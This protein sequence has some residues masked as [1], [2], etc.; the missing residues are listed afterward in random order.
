MANNA[1]AYGFGNSYSVPELTEFYRMLSV[2]GNTYTDQNGTDAKRIAKL[3]REVATEIAD[4]LVMDTQARIAL[5]AGIDVS[6][7]MHTDTDARENMGW[8]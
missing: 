3:Q 5:A 4:M 2:W 6:P 8:H 7:V 1:S